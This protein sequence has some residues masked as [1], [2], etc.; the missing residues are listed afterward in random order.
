MIATMLMILMLP[1]LGLWFALNILAEVIRLM[2][3]A[4]LDAGEW[5]DRKLSRAGRRAR[6][7]L[8]AARVWVR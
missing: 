7:L 3:A 5:A 4:A 6:G 1:F 8:A 2:L